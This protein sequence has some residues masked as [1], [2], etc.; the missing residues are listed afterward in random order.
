MGEVTLVFPFG[1]V[2]FKEGTYLL[3]DRGPLPV[4]SV[5]ELLKKGEK[6]KILVTKKA[7][8]YNNY[9]ELFRDILLFLYYN[10]NIYRKNLDFVVQITEDGKFIPKLSIFMN[11]YYG[12]ISVDNLA[13]KFGVT[14]RT[15]RRWFNGEV[16]FPQERERFTKVVC[17]DYPDSD[18]CKWAKVL[19]EENINNPYCIVVAIHRY[20]GMLITPRIP[21]EFKKR[22]EETLKKLVDRE[23]VSKTPDKEIYSSYKNLLRTIRKIIENTFGQK[24]HYVYTF[25]EVKLSEEKGI[26]GNESIDRREFKRKVVTLNLKDR[27]PGRKETLEEYITKEINKFLELVKMIIKRENYIIT[28]GSV[29]LI[30][31]ARNLEYVPIGLFTKIVIS[32]DY[33]E[34]QWYTNLNERHIQKLRTFFK[35]VLDKLN[36]G[37]KPEDKNLI[38]NALIDYEVCKLCEL[39]ARLLDI[40]N[41]NKVFGYRRPVF[42]IRDLFRPIYIFSCRSLEKRKHICYDAFIRI[43]TPNTGDIYKLFKSIIYTSEGIL[44][45]LDSYKLK[46]GK[47]ME[48]ILK[49]FYVTELIFS[50]ETCPTSLGFNPY[51]KITSRLKDYQI[52]NEKKKKVVKYLENV[53][54]Y[55]EQKLMKICPKIRDNLFSFYREYLDY[56]YN[57]F[58]N[59]IQKYANHNF[60]CLRKD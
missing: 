24:L 28:P 4:E 41:A 2:T 37:L 35:S 29:A 31:F 7:T 8:D 51:S 57:L 30:Y 18:F 45:E 16:I 32:S 46:L 55:I 43:I 11:K 9:E 49:W 36:I 54:Y 27:I 21:S 17:N 34:V 14:E 47:I 40:F 33:V 5:R 3:T 25:V 42:L 23:F 15:I 48:D 6:V 53:L 56:S 22:F 20:V 39:G 60:A 12:N 13:K 26:K 50:L 38:I 52:L 44:K 19:A 59:L 58:Y 10:V 1:A